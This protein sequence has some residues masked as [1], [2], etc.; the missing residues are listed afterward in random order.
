MLLMVLQLNK[1]WIFTCLPAETPPA[2]NY[3]Y[4]RLYNNGQNQFPTQEEDVK[5]AVNFL[6]SKRKEYNYADKVVLMGASA[7]AHLALLQGYKHTEVI[8]PKA[9]ISFFGPSDLVHLYNNPGFPI[10]PGT[11]ANILG[12]TPTQN[13]TIY[14]TSSPINY[15]TRQSPPTLLLQGDADLLVPPGQA[16]LLKEKLASAGVV[17]ELKIYPGEGHGFTPATMADALNKTVSFI[18]AKVQ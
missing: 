16:T 3:W 12:Y 8:M 11:L 18:K 2:P 5:A 15:V 14:T 4:Y 1:K 13:S 9:V 10:I 6:L 7:G 17:H